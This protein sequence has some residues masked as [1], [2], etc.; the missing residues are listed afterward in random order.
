[1]DLRSGIVKEARLNNIIRPIIVVVL[2]R[3]IKPLIHLK[4]LLKIRFRKYFCIGKLNRTE[5][6]SFVFAATKW[7]ISNI[8]TSVC[9]FLF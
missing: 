4:L 7:Q 3:V 2:R 9:V 1:M 8:A 6:F 5:I